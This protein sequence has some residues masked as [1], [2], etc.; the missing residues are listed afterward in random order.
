MHNNRTDVQRGCKDCWPFLCGICQRSYA[1]K[2][3]HPNILA[4]RWPNSMMIGGGYINLADHIYL[5]H[6]LF[7]SEWFNVLHVQ[8]NEWPFL[9][10]S[11]LVFYWSRTRL[12]LLTFI[13]YARQNVGWNYNGQIVAELLMCWSWSN[14]FLEPAL[15]SHKQELTS[16]SEPFSLCDM[17]VM[18]I[19]RMDVLYCRSR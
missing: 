16:I 19:W 15:S 10:S 4:A 9:K 13:L 1:L 8:H 12:I 18:W 6:T 5:A 11:R 2:I 14:Q 3:C 7:L 17:Q